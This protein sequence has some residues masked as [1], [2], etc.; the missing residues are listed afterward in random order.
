M[1]I[2]FDAVYTIL[3]ECHGGRHNIRALASVV[4]DPI[5]PDNSLDAEVVPANDNAPEVNNDHRIADDNQPDSIKTEPELLG[6]ELAGDSLQQLK[7]QQKLRQQEF[8]QNR[9]NAQVVN[10]D[11]S[12]IQ[13][14]VAQELF[15]QQQK[16]AEGA[17]QDTRDPSKIELAAA[18]G[19]ELAADAAESM[20]MLQEEPN[21]R[22]ET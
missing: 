22:V 20:R 18:D 12:E 2:N 10:D 17:Q 21:A 4:V 7:E 6:Q 3:S 5:N 16:D 9:Q 13:N 19:Q 8:E 11:K 1:K 14:D 15:E